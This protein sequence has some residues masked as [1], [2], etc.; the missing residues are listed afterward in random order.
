GGEAGAEDGEGI[1]SALA[2]HRGQ[3]GR[4]PRWRGALET[5]DDAAHGPR[6][7][8]AS[9]RGQEAAG[10]AGAG[11]AGGRWSP[12]QKSSS[13]DVASIS[14]SGGRPRDGADPPG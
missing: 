7:H 11:W 8:Q 9:H 13:V 5:C 6:I 2:R 1:P 4:V 12:R 14:V 10:K 3:G